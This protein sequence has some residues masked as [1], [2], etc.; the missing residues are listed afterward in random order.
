MISEANASECVNSPNTPKT[1]QTNLDD[2]LAKPVARARSGAVRDPTYRASASFAERLSIL[3]QKPDDHGM[4]LQRSSSSGVQS[5]IA[6]TN[7]P[8]DKPSP[9]VEKEKESSVPDNSDA[10]RAS[11]PEEPEKLSMKDWLALFNGQAGQAADTQAPAKG[12]LAGSIA[13]R[14]AAFTQPKEE[15]KPKAALSPSRS[16]GLA[17]R[18]ALLSKCPAVMRGGSVLERPPRLSAD[19]GNPGSRVYWQ[20]GSSDMSVDETGS[21]G[22]VDGAKKRRRRH[23]RHSNDL[24]DEGKK[25]RRKH[26][27]SLPESLILEQ[28][29]AEGLVDPNHRRRHSREVEAPPQCSRPHPIAQPFAGGSALG[30]RD[31]DS[32]LEAVVAAKPMVRRAARP[33]R[34]RRPGAL[35][36]A[37]E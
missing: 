25:S 18:I 8:G 34:G 15:E 28:L 31:D 22:S 32:Q 4:P 37:A 29:S 30:G 20:P 13:S 10:A 17:E 12:K 19:P 35:R 7:Q 2:P 16:G 23:H 1:Y 21:T 3:N 27:S 11:Q 5:K 36:V 14:I 9:L 6:A 26:R 33:I 24:G